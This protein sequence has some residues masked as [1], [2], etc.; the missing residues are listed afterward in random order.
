MAEILPIRRTIDQ[1]Y[2]K[3]NEYG[4]RNFTFTSRR[5][6]SLQHLYLNYSDAFDEK[7]NIE[8]NCKIM[9]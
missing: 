5:L 9:R 1:S 7:E 8:S 2:L 6:K 4:N 3:D